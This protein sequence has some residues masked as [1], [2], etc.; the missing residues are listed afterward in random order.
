MARPRKFDENTVLDRAM[1]LFWRHGYD[2]TS[3]AELLEAMEMTNSSLYKAFGSKADLFRR[4]TE[5][6]RAGPLAFRQMALAAYTPRSVVE[7]VLLG[8]VD[9]LSGPGT[10]QGCLEVTSGLPAADTDAGIRDLLISNRAV[11]RGL[12][13]ERLLETMETHDLPNG[14]SAEAM[15]SLVATIAHG[16]ATQ[17]ADGMD[18]ANLKRIVATFMATWD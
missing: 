5:R 10:P 3:T 2:G 7:A 12:L 11:L 14:T 9:L 15:A 6:Y 13:A 4:V 16:L 8:T 18:R 17:A 1:R